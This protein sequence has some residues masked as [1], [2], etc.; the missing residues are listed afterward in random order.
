MKVRLVPKEENRLLVWSLIGREFGTSSQRDLEGKGS[1]AIFFLP[2]WKGVPG[3]DYTATV[4]VYNSAG[5]LLESDIKSLH[6]EGRG[7]E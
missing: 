7:Q 3:G 5:K 6:V 1:P 4:S 2:P